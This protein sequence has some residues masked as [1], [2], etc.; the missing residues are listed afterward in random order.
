[1]ASQ[2]GADVFLLHAH[3]VYDFRPRDDMLFAYLSDRVAVAP[4]YQTAT[5]QGNGKGSGRQ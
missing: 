2:L 5:A 1:M 4:A 3:S